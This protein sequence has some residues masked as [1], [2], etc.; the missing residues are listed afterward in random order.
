[1][2]RGIQAKAPSVRTVNVDAIRTDTNKNVIEPKLLVRIRHCAGTIDRMSVAVA[3]HV[4]D[5]DIN[6]SLLPNYLTGRPSV[7]LQVAAQ[8]FIGDGRIQI[9]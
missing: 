8:T 2:Q 6:G 1:M 4:V 9:G 7:N 5:P 3:G